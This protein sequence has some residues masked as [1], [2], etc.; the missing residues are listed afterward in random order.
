MY[1]AQVGTGL[2]PTLEFYTLV[3]R[4]LQRADLWM[5]R[6]ELCPPLPGASPGNVIP[7][8]CVSLLLFLNG[9]LIKGFSPPLGAANTPLYVQS[10][11]GLFPCPLGPATRFS[12]VEEVC[13]KFRFLGKFIAKA[14]MDSRMVCVGWVVV[15]FGTPE[16]WVV[17]T[18]GTLKWWV[19]V[20]LV[21]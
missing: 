5:W 13:S 7:S 1:V 15:T 4:E 12:V 9:V 14:I 2:G 16:W 8:S 17:V 19:V 18:F 21:L 10:P 3:S 11:V 6:G 20:T